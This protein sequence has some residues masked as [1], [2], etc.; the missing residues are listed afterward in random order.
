MVLFVKRIIT[1]KWEQSGGEGVLNRFTGCV[2][3]QPEIVT[4][5]YENY[6]FQRYTTLLPLAQALKGVKRCG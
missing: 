6:R 3:T 5:L 4:I 1:N 2:A